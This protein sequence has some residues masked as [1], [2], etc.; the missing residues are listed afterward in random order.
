GR[1]FTFKNLGNSVS[2]IEFSNTDTTISEILG[3]DETDETLNPIDAVSSATKSGVYSYAAQ[4]IEIDNGSNDILTFEVGGGGD[5][6]ATLTSGIY[7][8][9]ELAVEIEKQLEQESGVDFTVQFSSSNQVFA[10]TNNTGSNVEYKFN[11]SSA[12]STLNFDP[13]DTG[14]IADGN[15][16]ISD[17]PR[18]AERQFDIITGTNDEIF[19]TD[20]G[21][22]AINDIIAVIPEGKYTGEELAAE[23]EKQLEETKGSSGQ[24]YT[25]T[26]DSINGQFK[27]I[28]GTSNLH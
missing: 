16:I 11:D 8:P 23:I 12:A 20:G 18:Y 28:N 10:I 27:I 3:F 24:D 22:D 7:T 13:V 5:L 6:R 2:I 26:F 1:T 9:D 19:F 25:V 21:V 17:D 15:T 14:L 4:L